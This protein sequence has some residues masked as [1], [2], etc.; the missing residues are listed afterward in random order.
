MDDLLSQIADLSADRRELLEQRL[1]REGGGPW[2]PIPLREG[3]GETPLSFAQEQLWFLDRLQPGNPWYNIAACVRF[4]GL[5]DPVAL[6][7]VLRGLVARHEV[8]RT[9]VVA[10][11]G[12]PVQT[13]APAVA[14]D[15]PIVNL[16][17]F[18]AEER[19]GRARGLAIEEARTPFDLARGPLLRARLLRLK[20]DEHWLLLTVHHIAADGWSMRVLVREL[21]PLSDAFA[22][23]EPTALP[24]LPLQ[25]A[26]Y[27]SWQRRRQEQGEFEP[28]LAYWKD[29]LRG[30]PSVLDLP[31]DH[32]RPATQTASGARH[33]FVLP[34]DLSEGV[35]G[36]ARREGYTSFMVL[37]AAFQAVLHR[38]SGQDD[39]CVGTPLAGRGRPELD[40]L[41]GDFVNTLVLRAD[42]SGDPTFREVL[43]RVR[44]TALGA[45]AH[46]DVPFEQLVE[47]LKPPRDPGR[48]PLVQVLFALDLEPD[49]RLE[50]PGLAVE[51]SEIDTGTA[52]FD[53]S[54]C[55]REG[56]DRLSGYL[57]YNSDLFDAETARRLVG[58]WHTLLAAALADPD[59]RV[60]E[61]PLLT[62]DE[63]RLILLDWNDT[64][65]PLPRQECLHQLVE[66]QVDRTPQAPAVI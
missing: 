47:V 17:A 50:L 43:E 49:P 34:E 21:A 2:S 27:S 48:S 40:G 55:L 62:D 56:A 51:F 10:R 41:V 36:L 59:G 13:I 38:Y 57:E 26:D 29:R 22:T 9:T 25:Y 16:R 31:T 64:K 7:Q 3:S 23:G 60:S 39:F 54:L 58:H 24:E 4:Q 61:L 66:V 33:P 18:S 19:P 44:E 53:L 5:L 8:L 37:L 35:R 65:A 6:E 20:V 1:R 46:P 15:M 11:D 30:A 28:Q 42:L 45:Y 14:L 52:K 63:R 12:R 32:P